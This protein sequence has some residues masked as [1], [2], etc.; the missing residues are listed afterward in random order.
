M[1]SELNHRQ[2]PVDAGLAVANGDGFARAVQPHPLRR[3]SVAE[4]IARAFAQPRSGG[5][6]H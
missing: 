2:S 3:W 4:L 5:L 6:A 1:N